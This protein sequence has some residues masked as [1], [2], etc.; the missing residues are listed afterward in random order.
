MLKMYP[1]AGFRQHFNNSSSCLKQA[2]QG[3]K[4][5]KEEEE[6]G[7]SHRNF[8]PKMKPTAGKPFKFGLA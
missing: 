6:V 5:E 1:Q 7:K 8:S 4:T 3:E 2:A